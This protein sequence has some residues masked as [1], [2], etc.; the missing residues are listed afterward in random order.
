M[1]DKVN[2]ISIVMPAYNE[3]ERIS[4]TI[5]NFISWV[6]SKNDYNIELIIVNDGSSD[7]TRNLVE[8]F[9]AKY[10]W[11]RLINEKHVG[12]MNAILSGIYN[13]KYDLIGTLEAD[14]PVSPEYFVQFLE[15]VNN[16]DIVIGS[17]FLGKTVKGKSL[18]RRIISRANSLLFTFLFSCKVKDP[19]ISFRLY[20]KSSII[21]ILDI[22]NLSHDGFKSTEIIVKAYGLGYKMK[23]LPVDYAHREDSKAVPGGFQAIEVTLRATLA[24]FQLWRQSIKDYKKGTL[25]YC[26]VR[27]KI[28]INY[29][30]I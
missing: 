3:E 12:M 4:S 1:S 6:K 19:Q 28:I 29:L 7:N 10:N 15:Y 5:E 25:D 20:N 26:P 13:A 14:S 8:S 16:Y 2:S 23:E 27:G 21:K 9:T 18:A 17:R 30:F 24:M 11:L 22:L